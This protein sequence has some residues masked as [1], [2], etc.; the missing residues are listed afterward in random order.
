MPERRSLLD[1]DATPTDEASNIFGDEFAVDDFDDFGVADGMY[2]RGGPS[3]TSPHEEVDEPVRTVSAYYASNPVVPNMATGTARNSTRKSRHYVDPNPFTDPNENERTSLEFEPEIRMSV[4]SASSSQFAPTHSPRF[5]AGPSHPYSIY[6]QGTVT[7]M[8]SI[9]TQSAIRPPDRQ[10]FSQTQ[11]QHPY[12]MYPQG[13]GD[14]MDDGEEDDFEVRQ[15]PVPVGFPGLAQNYTRRMGPDGED[16]DIIGEDGHTEQLPPYS[17]YPEDGPEKVPL[18]LPSAPTALHSRAP[19]AGTDPGMP[20]MHTNLR[21]A[22]TPVPQSMA[23]ESELTSHS[24]RMS[25]SALALITSHFPSDST[26]IRANGETKTWKEKNWKEKRKTRFCG[27]PFWWILLA[28]CVLAF[29]GAVLGGVIGGFVAGGKQARDR[30][31]AAIA[32]CILQ[33]ILT[34]SLSSQQYWRYIIV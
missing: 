22:P 6:P 1:G 16:Q 14:E 18:L 24:S 28:A 29:V 8:Q 21:A 5:G 34:L 26:S 12:A 31:V 33:G 27:I 4:S 19:V 7:R 11:P 2:G 30:S 32:Y 9:A 20:L 13:V 15:N 23:D 3:H 25:G 10:S 17:R